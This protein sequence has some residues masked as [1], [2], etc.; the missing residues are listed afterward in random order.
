LVGGILQLLIGAL[1]AGRFTP[2]SDGD[3]SSAIRF[4]LFNAGT[5]ALMAGF[6]VRDHR[7]IG[8]GGSAVVLAILMWSK[9][10]R[11]FLCHAE[12][13]ATHRF[14]YGFALLAL[15]GGLLVGAGLA[16]R[17]IE[18]GLGHARLAHIHLTVLAFLT[19]TVI[20]LLQRWVPVVLNQ[21]ARH[22]GVN[23][24]VL[25]LLP[26]GTAGLLTGFWLS[27]VEIQLAAGGLF[28]I[29]I[30]LHTY[31]QG[32]LWLRAGRP[33]TSTSDHLL[34]ANLFLLLATMMG[35]ALAINSLQL[36]PLLPYGT[37]HIVAY[38]HAAFL[39]FLLQAA[40]GGLSI[41]LPVQLAS[42]V[43]SKKKRMPYFVAMTRMMDKWRAVQ[44]FTL[45]C[46]TLGLSVLASLTWV[47]PLG[48][49]ILHAVTW[50]TAGLLV[51]SLA[52]FSAKIARVMAY[53]PRNLAE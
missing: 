35:L 2:A 51:V 27:S 44:L 20:G 24:A 7:I 31:N 17:F 52:L 40:V 19:L 11:H 45:T 39:G 1:L 21:A 8:A 48:S 6:A 43:P 25:I 13:E 46:G 29:G 37:L 10:I 16:F 41:L 26:G 9:E 28:F 49:P 33:G 50:T 18:T 47:M 36:P 5:V 53:R 38:T 22:P 42:Q 30:L 23:T 34:A 15:G 12:H 3:S 14:Y 32:R 4:L